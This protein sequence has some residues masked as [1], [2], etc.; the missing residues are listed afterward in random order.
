MFA[1]EG[2]ETLAEEGVTVFTWEVRGAAGLNT[3]MDPQCVVDVIANAVGLNVGWEQSLAM[4]IFTRNSLV[5]SRGLCR[6]SMYLI[7]GKSTIM[8]ERFTS[9]MLFLSKMRTS[10]QF[11]LV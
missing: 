9:V 6:R 1:G 7:L 10:T 8:A 2:V 11:C 5:Q 4:S 3:L